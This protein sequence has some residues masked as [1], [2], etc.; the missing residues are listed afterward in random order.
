MVRN[1]NPTLVL[2]TASPIICLFLAYRASS[3]QTQIT[4][5]NKECTGDN[6]HKVEEILLCGGHFSSLLTLPPSLITFTVNV[7][8]MFLNKT[9]GLLKLLCTLILKEAQSHHLISTIPTFIDINSTIK[10]KELVTI[11]LEVKSL[12]LKDLSWTFLAEDIL[13]LIFH[14]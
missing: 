12:L 8:L 6:R 3:L 1:L 11:G 4:E 10:S 5:A 14:S 2:H 7:N 9:E 13:L